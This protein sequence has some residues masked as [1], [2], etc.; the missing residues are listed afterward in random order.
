MLS[1]VSPVAVRK[2]ILSMLYKAG[3]SHLGSNMSEVEMLIAVF[4]SIDCEK[5]KKHENDRSRVFISKGHSAAVTYATMAH[6][7]IIPNELLETYHQDG[8]ML[9]GHVNH[10]VPGVEHS[11]GA[12][13]HGINVATGTALGF[14]SLGYHDAKAFALCG[15]G[16]IQEGSIWEA[17]MFA[18][19]KKLNNLCILIDNN[20]ISSITKTEDVIDLRPL[21]KRFEGFGLQA[22]EV[23][24]HDV[25][26]IRNCI[27]QMDK[28]TVPTVIVC[29]TVKGKDVPFAEWEPVWHYRSLNEELYKKAIDHLE[30]LENNS[31]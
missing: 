21:T 6:F 18:A 24:G 9:T 26:A 29:N 10:E 4:S 1:Q 12:L 3:A 13:G 19:H 2:T 7:G 16:E 28:A 14:R 17:V 8:S 25:D 22:F 5:I 11:T 15:D 31:K 30:N 27:K 23:D 20:R